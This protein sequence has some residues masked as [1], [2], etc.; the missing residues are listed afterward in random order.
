MARLIVLFSALGS[1]ILAAKRIRPAEKEAGISQEV[2]APLYPEARNL[3]AA[4]EVSLALE[5]VDHS[6]LLQG[7]H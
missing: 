3:L 2:H 7:M 6:K 4:V 1:E 5:A